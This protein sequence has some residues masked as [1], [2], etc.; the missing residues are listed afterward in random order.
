MDEKIDILD[1][2][3]EGTG[4]VAWKSEAHRD[5]LW[6]RCFHLWIVDPGDAAEGPS[7]LVQRRA[8]G[9]ETWPNKLDVT[10]AGHLM[11]GESGLDGL[12]ELEEELGLLVRPDEVI[13]LGTRRNELAIP[14]GMDREY[15]DV[16]LLVRR[17]V[18]SD[19]RLQEEEVASVARLRLGDVERLCEGEGVPLEEWTGGEGLESTAKI[20]DFVPG[21]DRYLP[22]VA[23]AAK[24]I[25]NGE[26]ANDAFRDGV[27]EG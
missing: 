23:R 7:L 16:F 12:R 6:H 20:E 9:K 24:K 13:P 11:A 22:L 3:G 27:R 5:G 10:A 17:L 14:A 26:Q 1:E 21:G 19:L 25:L 8:P 2:R 18:P 4:R 15:Q